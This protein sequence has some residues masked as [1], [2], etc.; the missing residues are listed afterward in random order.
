M[1]IKGLTDKQAAF[2]SLGVLRKGEKKVNA[3][4][5]GKDLTYFRFVSDDPLAND[6]FTSAYPNEDLL[7]NINVLLPFKT[8]D[9]NMDAWIEKWVAGGLIYR[10]D[11]ETVVLWRTDKGQFSTEIKPDPRPVIGEDGKR[12]DGSSQVGRLTVII[13]ELGR[14]A[15][16]TVLT[17][18]KWD[19]INLTRQLRSYEALEGDLRG[20]P[21][22]L[23]RTLETISTPT[24]NGKRSRRQ[25][26]LLSIETLPR[27]TIPKFAAL[28][29]AVLP[30]GTE[31]IDSNDYTVHSE[32]PANITDPFEEV[33]K[34]GYKEDSPE[35]NAEQSNHP[36]SKPATTIADRAKELTKSVDSQLGKPYY[37]APAHIYNALKKYTGAFSWPALEDEAGWKEVEASALLYAREQVLAELAVKEGEV[38]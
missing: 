19:I 18:S 17:T 35:L 22:V 20:I 28:E 6:M 31:I 13:P 24:G 30:A 38:Q 14:F 2:P 29:R 9:E 34:N 32:L 33:S 27:Y 3:N 5:P 7:R 36:P 10:S 1:A 12:A 37:N 26:W 4:A 25:K 11:G 8:T 16:L 23:K 15:T 21:F